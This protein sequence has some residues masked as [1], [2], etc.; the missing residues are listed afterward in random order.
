MNFVVI[1]GPPA[2]GKMTVGYEL[3][4]LTGMKVFHN[5]MTIDLVLEFFP[6]GHK[7]FHT[8]V[9]EFRRRIFEEVASSELPGMIFTYVWALDKPGDKE[10]ID[11]YCQIFKE[12]G[13]DIY[14]VELEASLDERLERNK[15][16]FRLSKKSSKRD[17]SRSERNLLQTEE[18]YRMNTDGDFFYEE[19]YVKINNTELSPEAT[20]RHISEEFG[21]VTV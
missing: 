15:S 16:E 2:V 19:N 20:A 3:A 1:F 13:A 7:K 21:F 11:S 9:N 10:Q 18:Q 12:R 8:L 6:Y 17:T 14:F 5:H 4:K